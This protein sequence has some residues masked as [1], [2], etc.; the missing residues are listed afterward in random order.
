[1]VAYH[2]E[3]T[4]SEMANK[5]SHTDSEAFDQVLHDIKT[6]LTNIKTFSYLLNRQLETGQ[7]KEACVNYVGKIQ[8]N[9]DRAISLLDNLTATVRQSLKNPSST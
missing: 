6:P 2:L 9:L 1:M 4:N 7:D 5:K 8:T 3:Y